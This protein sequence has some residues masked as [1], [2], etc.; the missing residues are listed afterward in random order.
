MSRPPETRRPSLLPALAL[1]G[2]SGVALALPLAPRARAIGGGAASVSQATSP[3]EV[4]GAAPA[5][6]LFQTSVSSYSGSGGGGSGNTSTPTEVTPAAGGTSG[7][8]RDESEAPRRRPPAAPEDG[9]RSAGR[10][11]AERRRDREASAPAA[12][13]ERRR[14][15]APS[16]G[17]KAV[18]DTSK[19]GKETI[20]PPAK[21]PIFTLSA[22]Y[23]TRYIYHGLDIIS[24]NSKYRDNFSRFN[25]G[26]EST[27]ALRAESSGIYFT[28]ASVEYKGFRG[29][30]GYVQAVDPT[31]PY[32]QNAGDTG[33]FLT[34]PGD[35]VQLYREVNI[36]LDYT[37]TLVP[38]WLDATVGFNTFFF[39][40]TDF[41]GT[42]YQGEIPIRLTFTR[43]PFVRPSF[44]YFRYISDYKKF[45]AGNL[46]GNY[47]EFRL[48][49]SVPIIDKPNF[50]LAIAPY[51]AFGYNINYLK[52]SGDDDVGGWN[53]FETG[54]KVPV[55]LGKHFTITPFGNYGKNLNGADVV[56]N[57]F[58]ESTVEG[59]GGSRS[60]GEQTRF[61]GGVNLSYAF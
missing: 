24:F 58:A 43:I 16:G 40:N 30:V 59:S 46:N 6:S 36:H 55:R 10:Q 1:L 60:F 32:F 31:V 42:A 38:R 39:P 28:D 57:S 35:T 14:E 19:G 29:G 50:G 21:G 5:V 44:S 9:G 12:R 20:V 7:G 17:G 34:F 3:R 47:V 48:D 22:G 53:T 13:S 23:Q 18:A 56:A 15:P 27:F 52:F 54:V 61:W 51:A 26:Q 41:K 33:G 45:G 8:G 37:V 11:R 49:G 2:V 25:S 4:S